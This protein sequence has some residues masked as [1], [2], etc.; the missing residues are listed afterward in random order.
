[1]RY[2]SVQSTSAA[3]Q[4]Q[5]R[6]NIYAAPFD[7]EAYNGIQ[8]NG[9]HEVSQ[10]N[11]GN[12]VSLNATATKYVVDGWTASFSHPSAQLRAQQIANASFPWAHPL[13]NAF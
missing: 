7:A 13:G 10:D 6:Q 1:M 5:A 4:Q 9:G 11:G 8:T 12:V 3:Q 2:D